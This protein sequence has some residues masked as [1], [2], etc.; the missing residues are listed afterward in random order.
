MRNNFPN[1]Y[2]DR[3]NNQEVWAEI[4]GE[5]RNNMENLIY[6]N[7]AVEL[8]QKSIGVITP[9]MDGTRLKGIGKSFV[10]KDGAKTYLSE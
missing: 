6:K 8:T 2:L 10:I 7:W 4:L 1:V 5:A 3:V 9:R